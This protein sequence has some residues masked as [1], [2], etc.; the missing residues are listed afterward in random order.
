MPPILNRIT[1]NEWPLGPA[2]EPRKTDTNFSKSRVKVSPYRRSLRLADSM[3]ANYTGNNTTMEMDITE[4]SAAEEPSLDDSSFL[5]GIRNI[6]GRRS[7]KLLKELPPRPRTSRPAASLSLHGITPVNDQT[8][9]PTGTVVGRKRK[10]ESSDGIEL[11]TDAVEAETL[12]SHGKRMRL[13]DRL[14]KRSDSSQIVGINSDLPLTA[15][16]AS[17][18]TIDPESL[19]SHSFA[20]Q[21]EVAGAVAADKDSKKCIIM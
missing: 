1:S 3:L 4:S 18:E 6:R 21:P 10:P 19:K 12:N 17:T 8:A 5:S 16:V 20:P 9:R 2:E 7:Y 11:A 14:F 13:L 15:P